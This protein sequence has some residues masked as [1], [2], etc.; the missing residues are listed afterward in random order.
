V[1]DAALLDT[2]AQAGVQIIGSSTPPPQ[3]VDQWVAS[4]NLD[5]MGALRQIW[6]R[7]LAGE[8]GLNLST[9]LALGERN[10]ALFSLGRQ[11][12]VDKMLTDLLAG[13]VDTGVDPQTG[14]KR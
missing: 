3:F 4:I 2:L 7:L 1:D 11:R 14:E 10:A 6:S 12:L 9:P 13:Y 8:G 5:E